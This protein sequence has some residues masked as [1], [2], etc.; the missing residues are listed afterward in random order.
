M[1]S[2]WQVVYIF[3][4]V[5]LDGYVAGYQ[6]PDACACGSVTNRPQIKQLQCSVSSLLSTKLKDIPVLATVKLTIICHGRQYATFER[7]LVSQLLHLEELV[8]SNCKIS[9][10]T[11]DALFGMNKLIVL[12]IRNADIG[13]GHDHIPTATTNFMN[14]TNMMNRTDDTMLELAENEK[15][16]KSPVEISHTEFGLVPDTFMETPN[17]L[18]LDLSYNK[19]QSPHIAS[20]LFCP[21]KHLLILDIRG[22]DFTALPQLG[23][24]CNNGSLAS[25]QMLF[26]GNYS[27]EIKLQSKISIPRLQNLQKLE[28]QAAGLVGFAS[29]SF[30]NIENLKSL[31]VSTNFL[32]SM[33]N[34]S[35]ATSLEYLSVAN[36]QLRG[37]VWEEIRDLDKLVLLNLSRNALTNISVTAL[38]QNKRLSFVDLSWNKLNTLP[39]MSVL[40]N[41]KMLNLSNNNINSIDYQPYKLP[42]NLVQL[43]LH[44]NN[45]SSLNVSAFKHLQHL[46]VL[47][48]SSNQISQIDGYI[49]IPNLWKLNIS[50]NDLIHMPTFQE[51]NNIQ[52]LSASNNVIHNITYDITGSLH[53]MIYLTLDHNHIQEVPRKVFQNC[54]YLRYINLAHNNISSIDWGAFSL[55]LTYPTRLKAIDLSY[56]KITD[57][58]YLFFYLPELVQLHLENNF[59]TK[60]DKYVFPRK[61]QWITLMNNRI[62]TIET[63]TFAGLPH[64]ML[65]D[66]R[67][68]RLSEFEKES[69]RVPLW[70]S[71]KQ[72]PQ[73]WLQGNK[74]LCVCTNLWIYETIHYEIPINYLPSIVDIQS[75]TCRKDNGNQSDLH[76]IADIGQIRIPCITKVACPSYCFCLRTKLI[77][78][79]NIRIDAFCNG[80]NLTSVPKFLEFYRNFS[81]VNLQVESLRLD[82]NNIKEIPAN[83]MPIK[84]TEIYLNNSDIEIIQEKAFCN[85]S[86]LE[87][88]HLNDN[89]ISKLAKHTFANLPALH[90][91]FL[92]NNQIAHIHINTFIF[93]N[94][95]DIFHLNKNQ[96]KNLDLI[97]QNTSRILSRTGRTSLTLADNLWPCACNFTLAFQVWLVTY[98]DIVRDVEDIKC[99]DVGNNSDTD[100]SISPKIPII[101]QNLEVCHPKNLRII[102]KRST[103]L[104]VASVS[105]SCIVI[106]ILIVLLTVYNLKELVKVWLFTRY[107]FRF[108]PQ[109]ED[110]NKYFDAFL[111][112]SSKDDQDLVE[113]FVSRLENE[114]NNYRICLH[115]RD[116]PVGTSIAESVIAS[117]ETSK[118]T[119]ILLSENFVKSEWCSYE[120]K[121]AHHKLLTDKTNRV[122]VILLEK[123]SAKL[124]DSDLKLYLKTNTYLEWSDPRFWSKLQYAMPV[125]TSEQASQERPETGVQCIFNQI[126]SD[127]EPTTHVCMLK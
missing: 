90:K 2:A 94:K 92:Q 47:D 17:L 58:R 46:E 112:Y 117:V 57:V 105:V 108:R 73:F 98:S 67:N 14:N 64:L 4:L 20:Q 99:H 1:T 114:P 13:Q 124:L 119:I 127:K 28:I 116:W 39:T 106:V 49:T 27:P 43:N 69:A 12:S 41:V 96:L 70:S 79:N 54:S 29:G 110:E 10:M 111:S 34:V 24:E 31:D 5:C 77:Q 122:I 109:K 37:R 95:L 6:C 97:M 78:Q 102:Y 19:L 51:G 18:W 50:N 25:L 30:E 81:D 88:L 26:L 21:L 126:N 71:V 100:N 63:G 83:Q 93:T 68:N 62:K 60:L 84:I 104:V 113:K 72:R 16:R 11:K 76:K 66:L 87:V 33:P 52:L 89:K 32:S 123:I 42:S 118:R 61:I 8:I 107:G 22:N 40:N 7:G 103:V 75:V 82:G 53:S 85:L 65:V 48:L 15:A 101:K 3:V 35:K 80:K 59:I 91:L 9:K 86:Y 45:I 56:N 36:N 121:T 115:Y 23:L 74:F 44:N 120:F 125:V 55:K 38:A